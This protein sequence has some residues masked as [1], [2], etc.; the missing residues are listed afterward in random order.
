MKIA[1]AISQL[2]IFWSIENFVKS[3]QR[4]KKKSLTT[5]TK[6]LSSYYNKTKKRYGSDSIISASLLVSI[7]NRR[8]KWLNIENDTNEQNKILSQRLQ[9]QRSWKLIIKSG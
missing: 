3:Y 2:P 1:I 8:S 5:A 4:K 7:C 6:S 9:I